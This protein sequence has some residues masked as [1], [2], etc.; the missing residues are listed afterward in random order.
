MFQRFE[1]MLYLKKKFLK[2]IM[3]R[4]INK[5]KNLFPLKKSLI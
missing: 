4:K 1:Y 3:K 2:K 5:N